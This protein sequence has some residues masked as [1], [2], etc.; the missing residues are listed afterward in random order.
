MLKYYFKAF[1]KAWINEI[2][3]ASLIG[4]SLRLKFNYTKTLI[5]EGQSSLTQYQKE[6]IMKTGKLTLYN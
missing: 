3:S 2:N 1:I 4:T 6:Y 5:N